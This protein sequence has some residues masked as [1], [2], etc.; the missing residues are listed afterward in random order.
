[1]GKKKPRKDQTE[2]LQLEVTFD[3]NVTDAESLCS[4][5][6]QLLETAMSTPGILDEYGNP[7]VGAFSVLSPKKS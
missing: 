6:D 5:L 1:M 3:A 7:E 2:V 4:A